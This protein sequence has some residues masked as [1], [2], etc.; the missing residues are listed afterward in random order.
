VI[1]YSA[2]QWSQVL[3]YGSDPPGG[4]PFT[5]PG[6]EEGENE[7]P[8]SIAAE[9]G[10]HSAWLA[11]DP[12][13]ALRSGENTI[14]A[15]I[16]A[17][18]EVSE[19]QTLPRPGEGV[20]AR[21]AAAKISCPAQN[22]CWLATAAGYLFHYY[23]AA[24][25]TQ[26]QDA[27]PAF[28]NLITFRPPDAGVPQVVPD[29]P[30]VDDSGLLGE[31][32]SNVSAALETGA[33]SEARVPVALLSRLRSRLLRG[34]T[35]E[36]RFHLAVTARVRLIAKRRKRVVASTPQRTLAGGDHS[37]LLKLN[38]R[39][40]P[41]KLDLQT[42]ALA[43]LPTESLRGAGSGTVGTDFHVLP[44]TLPHATTGALP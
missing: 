27:D 31:L 1:H 17:G 29:A 42:Q 26:P 13:R 9:P 10:T 21:G 32:S 16:A 23:D 22:D 2:G 5:Q 18:G 14:V 12:Q 11:L 33:V 35:L 24:H 37:L 8:V 43:P 4:N 15:R 28:A 30:P 38:R 3:G 7:T 34:T 6:R 25:R 40:W 19:R 41:T 39:A 36:L 20:T 44:R